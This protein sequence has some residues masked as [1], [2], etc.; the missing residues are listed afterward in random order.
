[1]KNIIT[2]ICILFITSISVA[3]E[4]KSRT[5]N[6]SRSA[7]S[8]RY[9]TAKQAKRNPSTTYTTRRER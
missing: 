3:Q 8:G 7:K 6:Q 2:L 9:V 1:M 5:H 4:R